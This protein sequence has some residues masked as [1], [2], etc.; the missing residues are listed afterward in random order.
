MRTE[1]SVLRARVRMR[2]GWIAAGARTKDY[3]PR[4]DEA[5]RPKH[6]FSGRSSDVVRRVLVQ[7]DE[8]DQLR[9]RT[10]SIEHLRRER[11]RVCLRIVNRLF[12]FQHAELR[13]PEALGDRGRAGQRAAADIEPAVVH[14]A[15][16]LDDER[17][18]VPAA[19]RVAVVPGLDFISLRQ[20]PAVQKHLTD[21][22]ARCFVNQQHFLWR[23]DDLA[24]IEVRVELRDAHRQA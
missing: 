10:E 1:S 22:R 14:E 15:G 4:T 6:L 7:T 24:R 16:R 19:Y 13:P 11:L 21:R 12:E 18:A 2:A 9:V 5:P 3:G 17:V 8:L 23:L 20:L